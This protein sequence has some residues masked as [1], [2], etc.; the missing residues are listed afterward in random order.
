MSYRAVACWGGA[1]FLL[2]P[3]RGRL[4]S[5]YPVVE[6]HLQSDN[7]LE[8]SQYSTLRPTKLDKIKNLHPEAQARGVGRRIALDA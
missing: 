2:R 5:R 3:G 7:P 6:G 4:G 8:S 1:R